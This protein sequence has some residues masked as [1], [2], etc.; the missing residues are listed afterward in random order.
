MPSRG[1]RH[2]VLAVLASVCSVPGVAAAAGPAA[3]T[4]T[5]CKADSITVAGKVKMTGTAARKVRGAALQLRFHALPLFG[6]PR[7]G[8][9]HDS[10]KKSKASGQET[11]NTLPA[12][13][14]VGVMSWRFKKGRKTVASGDERSQPVKAGSKKGRSS[15]T[16]ALG[17]KPADSTPPAIYLLPA[18][19]AWHR[20]AAT[21]QVVAQDGFSGVQSTRYSLDGGPKTPITN[22]GTFTIPDQGE[23]K[24]DVESTDVAG[25]TGTKNVVIKVDGGPPSKP[26]LARPGAVTAGT[27]PTFQWSASTDSGSGLRGYLVAIR[28][29]DGSLVAVQPVDANTTSLVSPTTLN[30]GETYTVTVRA[31]DNTADGAWEIDSDALTFRVDSHADVTGVS[32]GAGTVLSG[33]LKDS[34]FTIT[35]DRAADPATVSQ[36]TVTLDRNAESGSDPSFTVGCAN[37]PCTTISLDPSG[38]LQEGRY[39][40]GLNGVKSAD[41]ALTFQAFAAAY[42]VPFLEDATGPPASG[43]TCALGPLPSTR[44]VTLNAPAADEPATISF[45]WSYSGGSGW[46]AQAVR[47]SDSQPLG[48]ATGGGNGSG[49][50]DMPITI[51][52]T[53]QSITIKFTRCPTVGSTPGTLDTTNLIGSRNP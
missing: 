14:W 9:W 53:T 12:D 43:G 36:S 47:T 18:D 44:I 31:I 49:H 6:L 51:P 39:V 52:A 33:S 41:E 25:N 24:V 17:A 13:S 15:C 38:S 37:S 27:K 1:T 28:H 32:P 34:T 20:A 19:G 3:V 23:H 45:D 5:A 10:G 22:G 7:S 46:S 21:V 40:L 30:D 4:I 48:T 35:L 8:Q 2:L 50:V 29:P 16:I 11:F 42:T 26:A